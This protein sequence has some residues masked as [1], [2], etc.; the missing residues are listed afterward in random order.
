MSKLDTEAKTVK[1]LIEILSKLNPDTKLFSRYGEDGYEEGVFLCEHDMHLNKYTSNVDG[2]H[3]IYY[4]SKEPVKV[5][6]GIII[7]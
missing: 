7:G 1:E 6:T 5:C 3:E 2:P 4:G